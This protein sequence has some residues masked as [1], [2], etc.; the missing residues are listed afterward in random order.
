M[1]LSSET[2]ETVPVT[3]LA[4]AEATVCLQEFARVTGGQLAH[5]QNEGYWVNQ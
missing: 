4:V 1:W 2:L 5:Q 3:A